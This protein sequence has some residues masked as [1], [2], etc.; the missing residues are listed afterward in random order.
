[1][2]KQYLITIILFFHVLV[3]HA[4]SDPV[5]EEITERVKTKYSA[6]DADPEI[7][8]LAQK[9]LDACEIKRPIIIMQNN[10]DNI[11]PG[12]VYAEPKKST[13]E[14]LILSVADQCLDQIEATIYHEIGHLHNGDA[15]LSR[16]QIDLYLK[17]FLKSA[18][19]A[20]A[21]LSFVKSPFKSC[22][23]RGAVAGGVGLFCFM[24]SAFVLNYQKSKREARA[25]KF[26]YS[27]LVEHGKVHT[28]LGQISD[29]LCEYEHS[30]KIKLSRVLTGYPT[31]L[32]RAKI[33]LQVVQNAGYDIA[34]LI[35]NP[36]NELD[37]GIKQ[38]LPG[39]IKTFFPEFLKK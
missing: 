9:A 4:M 1:M 7:K 11:D 33:G 30:K 3:G 10:K 37:K 20:M 31:R 14:Y 36:P 19:V 32:E 15:Q 8:E 21:G 23:V 29:Y 6:K 22:I 25:D 26:A 17:R 16:A 2:V 24:G 39:Q 12:Y 5:I 28:A 38:H 34:H 13:Q 35:N 27:K 18:S